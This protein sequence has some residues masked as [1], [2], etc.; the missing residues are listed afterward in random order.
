MEIRTYKK[1]DYAGAVNALST[2]AVAKII[3]FSKMN[4]TKAK[5]LLFDIGLFPDKD[6]ETIIVAVEDGEILGVLMLLKKN[7]KREMNLKIS[8]LK[9]VLKYG[10][11]KL[12]KI[13][14]GAEAIYRQPEDDEL[15][16]ELV[17][18]S[19]AHTGKGIG[20]KLMEAAF[21]YFENSKYKKL[22]LDVLDANVRAHKLYKDLGFEDDGV[23]EL[24]KK[25]QNRLNG[26]K[27]IY[28]KY[29]KK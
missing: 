15:Y 17:S 5:Q 6:D 13:I 18:V 16:I 14:K 24:S 23:I 2:L 27:F 4:E 8:K 3:D 28:M 1:E 9:L 22:T 20:S 19:K 29:E 7:M 10:P 12:L 26:E 25:Y 21:K 11:V